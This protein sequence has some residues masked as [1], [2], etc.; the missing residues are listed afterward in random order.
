MAALPENYVS[1]QQLRE[2]WLQR[3]REGQPAEAD[4]RERKH[5]KRLGKTREENGS[6]EIAD[7]R[8]SYYWSQNKGGDGDEGRGRKGL[9]AAGVPEG[10]PQEWRYVGREVKRGEL[11]RPISSDRGQRGFERSSSGLVRAKEDGGQGNGLRPSGGNKAVGGDGGGGGGNRKELV[12]PTAE[13]KASDR[14]NPKRSESEDLYGAPKARIVPKDDRGSV[15]SVCFFSVVAEESGGKVVKREV[16]PEKG[17]NFGKKSCGKNKEEPGVVRAEEV[18]RGGNWGRYHFRGNEGGHSGGYGRSLRDEVAPVAGIVP[19]GQRGPS[20]LNFKV[21]LDDKIPNPVPVCGL[22]SPPEKEPVESVCFSGVVVEENGAKEMKSKEY[23]RKSGGGCGWRRC[24][25]GRNKLGLLKGKEEEDWVDNLADDGRDAP[26]EAV[27]EEFRGNEM[28]SR[29]DP[30]RSNNYKRK[31]GKKKKHRAAQRREKEVQVDKPA[32]G[33]DMPLEAVTLPG[34]KESMALEGTHLGVNGSGNCHT[35]ISGRRKNGF[36]CRERVAI[37]ED[38]EIQE[39]FSMD[40]E[41]VSK[42]VEPADMSSRTEGKLG[43]RQKNDISS[44]KVV[45][46]SDEGEVV[47]KLMGFSIGSTSR[48]GRRNKRWSPLAENRRRRMR[49]NS[50]REIRAVAS[51]METDMIWVKKGVAFDG[52]NANYV[53]RESGIIIGRTVSRLAYEAPQVMP[54]DYDRSH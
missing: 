45:F 3:Q 15:E 30:M 17:C 5:D 25:N 49:G 33:H 4:D 18:Q 40:K 10:F 32:D 34:S 27:M 22:E 43:Y 1:L 19:L 51:R 12:S 9:L 8:R 2:R 29:E 52:D 13:S 28:R 46:C 26:A 16:F 42:E 7:R 31:G 23:E 37:R 11:R 21:I 14:P 53:T 39:D 54:S 20:S 35:V 6:R 41:A 38:I 50:E 47:N 44:E 36:S 48:Q 24:D